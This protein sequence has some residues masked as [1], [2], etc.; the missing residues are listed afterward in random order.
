MARLITK[1]RQTDQLCSVV[2]SGG[3]T[4]SAYLASSEA[5]SA[6]WYLRDRISPEILGHILLEARSKNTQQNILYSLQ[7]VEN[8]PQWE[9]TKIIFACDR[10]RWFRVWALAR[11]ICK[12]KN[13]SFGGVIG[14][15]R[16]DTHPHSRWWRQFVLGLRYLCCPYSVIEAEINSQ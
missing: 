6:Y 7:L 8:G 16:P 2:I 13:A 4:D 12:E 1:I 5:T 9:N 15:P 3:A 14:I 10:V 11:R